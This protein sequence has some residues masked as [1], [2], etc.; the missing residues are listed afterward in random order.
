MMLCMRHAAKNEIG[1]LRR[2]TGFLASVGFSAPFIGMFGSVW[3]IIAAFWALGDVK[4]ATLS[5]VAPAIACA[6]IA[7]AAGLVVAIPAILA[8][9]WMQG[10][11]DLLKEDADTFVE[12]MDFRIRAERV[13]A[14]ADP[15]EPV[16]ASVDR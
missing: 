6:L 4:S 5:T 8:L 14:A 16:L 13:G 10:R 3:G 7:T 9:T 15:D 2:G 11:I 1:A 12:R